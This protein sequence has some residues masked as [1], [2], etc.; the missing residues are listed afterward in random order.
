ML[1]NLCLEL[2]LAESKS[3]GLGPTQMR[4]KAN[5]LGKLECGSTFGTT[6][7]VNFVDDVA[8]YRVLIGKLRV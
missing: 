3:D 6:G 2:A 8:K 1:R 4:F 5:Q 7:A